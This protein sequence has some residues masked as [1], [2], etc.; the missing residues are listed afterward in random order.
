MSGAV[1][2]PMQHAPALQGA[3]T[4]MAQPQGSAPDPA[5][6][7]RQVLTQLGQQAAQS[8]MTFVQTAKKL[9]GADQAKLDQGGAMLR[10]GLQIVAAALSG[11]RGQ[12]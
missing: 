6:H 5:Q 7:G 9:P 10:Q 11:Q 2:P 3:T 4:G 12:Q 8:C 1:P